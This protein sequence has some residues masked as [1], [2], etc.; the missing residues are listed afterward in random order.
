M[1]LL[2]L[3]PVIGDVWTDAMSRYVFKYL[4]PDTAV[5]TWG[6]AHGPASIEGEYDE[7]LAAPE[8]VFLCEK[9]EREGFDGI[10]IN[11][12][13][14]PGVRAA[15]ERVDIP[16]FG[17]FEPVMHMALGTADKVCI[18]TVLPH[19]ISMIESAIARARL[20]E[21]V[22]CIRNIN[23]PVL[24]LHDH[25]KVIDAAVEHS[26]DAIKRDQAQSIIMSCTGFVDVA[27]GV[28]Q[29]LLDKGYDTAVLEASQ[30][31][32]MMLE[33][34]AVMGLRHSRLTYLPPREKQ[35]QWW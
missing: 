33:S 7:A 13:G 8:T 35:R 32:M 11:C 27:E 19:V 22:A 18:I 16:V 24:D 6:L 31:A 20:K 26:I 23:V 10:F 17:G 5:E 3:V 30:S 12:F 14:D 1:K 29:K 34:Y 28:Q 2:N 21:R 4:R 15:R 9:A 25:Q